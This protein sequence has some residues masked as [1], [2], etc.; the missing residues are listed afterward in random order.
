GKMPLPL[1]FR[2]PTHKGRRNLGRFFS[3]SPP[4]GSLSLTIA[5]MLNMSREFYSGKSKYFT[6]AIQG[7]MVVFMAPHFHF[8]FIIPY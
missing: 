6:L 8:I 7:R 3:R 1:D 5:Q 2:S 4:M